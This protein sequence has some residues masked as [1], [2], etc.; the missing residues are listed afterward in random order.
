MQLHFNAIAEDEPG[1]KW[2]AF[3][4]K[5]W[6]AY[7]KWFLSEG[8]AAR[9]S[10]LESRRMLRQYVPELVPTYERLL[11][12]AGGGD[13]Q[14]RLLSLYRPPP[15]IAGCSQAVWPDRHESV[16][17]R[18]Y[19]YSPRL[20][21]GSLLM[22]RWNDKRVIAMGDCLWGVL[23]GMND[24]GLS[25]SLSFGGRKVVGYGFG[26]PLILRY[27]LEF[28]DSTEQAVEVLT[29]IP[30]HMSYNVTLLDKH[31]QFQ[32][33]FLSPD[34]APVIRKIPVATNHQGRIEWVRH[35]NATSSLERE[36]FLSCRLA[37]TEET[38][39]GFIKS[40]LSPPLYSTEYDRGF[41]TVYTSVYRP[42]KG[43]MELRWPGT[44][45]QHSFDNF[46]EGRR[47]IR[48]PSKLKVLA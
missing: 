31:G 23:D 32:T 26:V 37:D 38:E 42:A 30:T 2:S 3:F 29:H 39:K 35:A 13:Q 6:P 10:Y 1:E 9:P 25:V 12:L 11:N 27:V 33:A 16:L 21:E 20:C 24:D 28:C 46:E 17:V 34:R 15:Y 5:H 19:D 41:G 43:Q 48:Y 4:E 22:T 8:D 36:Q 40:F 14:A 44:T 18:N 47:I 45:W 7:H